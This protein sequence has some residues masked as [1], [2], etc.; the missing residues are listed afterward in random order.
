MEKPI[1]KLFMSKP[2]EAWYRLTEDEKKNLQIRLTDA[3]EKV[4]GKSII[5]CFSGW[6]SER[7][8]FFSVEEFPSIEA[9]GELTPALL[10]LSAGRYFETESFLGIKIEV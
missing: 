7:W 3:L 2:K 8:P 5:S 10:E 4:G 9:V 6:S 1:Y